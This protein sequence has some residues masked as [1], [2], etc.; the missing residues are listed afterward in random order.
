MSFN[1]LTRI[2][3]FIIYIYIIVLIFQYVNQLALLF[4]HKPINLTMSLKIINY[5]NPCFYSLIQILI[6]NNTLIIPIATKNLFVNS[7]KSDIILRR[8][9]IAIIFKIIQLFL[10]KKRKKERKKIFRKRDRA[11]RRNAKR[12][13]EYSHNYYFNKLGRAAFNRCA[14][15]AHKWT[16]PAF[17]TNFRCAARTWLSRDARFSDRDPMRGRRIIITRALAIIV[18]RGKRASICDR[19]GAKQGWKSGRG[20]KKGDYLAAHNGKWG[21]LGCICETNR[22]I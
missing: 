15:A 16:H 19:N 5:Y 4:L 21:W 12:V 1:I 18:A 20:T 6:K 22:F 14:C 2:W 11:G 10:S 7:S 8:S 13:G 3:K 9:R 17:P